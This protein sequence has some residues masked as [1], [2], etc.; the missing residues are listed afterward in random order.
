MTSRERVLAVAARKKPDRLPKDLSWGLSAEKEA[1]FRQRTGREDY[2]EYFGLDIRMLEFAPATQTVDYSA[3]YHGRDDGYD[4]KIDEWGVGTYR[5]AQTDQHFVHQVPPLQGEITEEDILAYPLPDFSPGY[6]H[7]HFKETVDT[8]HKQGL[9][10]TG[11]L[12]Q[13]IFEQT[14]AIRGFEDAMMDMVAEPETITLLL[15]RVLEVR[16]RQALLYA[17]AGVD[18]L[19][20][21][22]DV[23]MQT[24]MLISV[25][26]WREFIKPRHA[27]IIREVKAVRPDLPIFYHSCGNC[28]D[29][30]PELIEIGV[31]ILNP[32]QPECM[33][34]A[35]I[36][37]TYGDRLAF[38]GGLSAQTNLSF[39]TPQQVRDEVKLRIDTLGRDGGYLIGPNHVVEPEVPWEN[40]MAFIEAVET[41][42]RY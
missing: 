19:M 24:G 16:L 40:L 34:Q 31:D 1:E 8:W 11:P 18:I 17:R 36:K 29:I 35:W 12:S 39:G 22:D 25:P 3:Y 42:G 32:L 20:L 30:I 33:D 7:A 4:F 21:G 23:G 2:W 6:R 10:V 38:W 37:K 26:L 14:W 41:Y 5:S 15:D 27:R 9:A 13:T 28:T